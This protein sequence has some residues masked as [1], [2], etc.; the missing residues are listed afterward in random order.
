MSVINR[1]PV[2]WL[3]F[4]GIKNFGKNPQN[5]PAVLAPTWDLEGLYLASEVRYAS[6]VAAGIAAGNTIVH[7]APQGEIWAVLQYGFFVGTLAAS[8]CVIN[9][10]VFGQNTA[11]IALLGDSAVLGASTVFQLGTPIPRVLYLGAGE[12]LGFSCAQVVGTADV[13]TFLR[14]V[15][16]PA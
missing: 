14:Y 2:G 6:N 13:Q 5:V 9:P 10:C 3:G 12:S 1:Q 8:S 4:L 15:A 16:L 7:T 11:Q